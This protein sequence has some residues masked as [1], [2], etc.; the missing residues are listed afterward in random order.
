LLGIYAGAALASRV[1]V[2]EIKEAS[3]IL[4]S[5]RSSEARADVH[6][7][8]LRCTLLSGTKQT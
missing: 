3:G 5:P 2:H 1:T 6:A 4:G 8:I 7:R